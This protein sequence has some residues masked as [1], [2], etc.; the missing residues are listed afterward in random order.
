MTCVPSV[1]N[2]VV[3]WAC[4]LLTATGLPPLHTRLVVP[5]VNVTVPSFTVLVEVTVAVKVTELPGGAVKDG[6][7]FDDTEVVVE[8]ATMMVAKLPVIDVA[9]LGMWKLV[10][11]DVVESNV[12]V[13]L[14][15]QLLNWKPALAVA[16]KGIV[17]LAA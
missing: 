17:A 9:A 16:V 14:V 8:A 5:S 1:V 15:V 13:P 10:L 4:P 11:A 2:E 3:H 7:L 12:P 6:L